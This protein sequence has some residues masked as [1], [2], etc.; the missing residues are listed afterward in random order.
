MPSA[1]NARACIAS[2]GMSALAR[3]LILRKRVGPV[4]ELQ[5]LRIVGRRR[6]R[7]QLALDHAAGSAIERDPVAFFEGLA[8]DAHLAR[9]F[10]DVNVAR[11]GHAA[12]AHAAGDDRGVTG[13][14]AARSENACRD[15]HAVDVFRRGFSAN[16]DDGLSCPRARLLD[17]FI[18]SEND[19]A[20]GGSRGSGQ[21]RGQHFDL[22]ALLIQARNQEVVELVRIDAEDGLFLGDQAFLDHLNR[23]SH[24][25]QAGALAVARLQH[26]ELAVLHGE[27]EVLDVAIV[28]LQPRG[29]VA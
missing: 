12:L 25:G 10:V 26:V 2:R 20:D 7:I 17:G 15:F 9:L 13:H 14:T 3:T 29:D 27:L 4:H 22:T 28:L 8:L 23:N 18:G 16:Q 5:K 6:D 1:P 24:R 19:L 21:A 11:A